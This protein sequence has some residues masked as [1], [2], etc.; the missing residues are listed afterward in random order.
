MNGKLIFDVGRARGIFALRV[1]RQLIFVVRTQREFSRFM[2]R[3]KYH[4]NAHQSTPDE[5]RGASSG[6]QKVLD[7]HLLEL[8]RAEGEVAGRDFVAKR[9]ADLRDAKRQLFAPG[10]LHVARS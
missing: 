10:S 6:R 1:M 5:L 7:F 2:P 4:C 8:A 3:I 9:L